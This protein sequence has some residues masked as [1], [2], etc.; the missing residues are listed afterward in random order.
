[1]KL[2]FNLIR[3][4]KLPVTGYLIDEIIFVH[5]CE[6]NN[7]DED[8]ELE[9]SSSIIIWYQFRRTDLIIDS[10][11]VGLHQGYAIFQQTDG[12]E[13]RRRIGWGI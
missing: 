5:N 3:W 2:Q 13:F 9:Y 7:L 1:M 11:D 4:V 10:G 6:L 8:V 12:R